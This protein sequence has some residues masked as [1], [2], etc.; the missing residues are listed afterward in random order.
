MKKQPPQHSLPTKLHGSQRLNKLLAA[1]GLGSR[2]QV[3]ELIEQ[4]RV[5]VDGVIAD[6]LGF[7][8]DADNAKILVDGELLRQFRPTYFALNKPAGVLCTNRDP[9]GRPRAIDYLP[10]H[11]RLFPV[12]RLDASSV[13]LLLMTN[14]G[15]L[16]QRL[17]HPKHGVPKTYFVVVAGHIDAQQLKR[18]QRGIYLAEGLAK[19]EGARIKRERKG[20]TELEITLCEGKNREIRRVL[21]KLGNKVVLLRRVS[22]GPL[23]LADLPEGAYRPLAPKEVSAL[24]EAAEES[25]KLRKEARKAGRTRSKNEA[26][27]SESSD[28]AP[29]KKRVSEKSV[30]ARVKKSVL[31]SKRPSRKD[32]TTTD[33]PVASS[34]R[35]PFAWDDDDELLAASPFADDFVQTNSKF[36]DDDEDFDG[37]SSISEDGNMILLRDDGSSSKRQRRVVGF[38]DSDSKPVDRSPRQKGA[39]RRTSPKTEGGTGRVDRRAGAPRKKGMRSSTRQRSRS[40]S[41]SSATSRSGDTVR[42]SRAPSSSSASRPI[43]GRKASTKNLSSKSG[44]PRGKGRGIKKSSRG[45]QSNRNP[46]RR[47]SR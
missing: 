40:G 7:K 44:A 18:L 41:P 31:E 8:V 11:H 17:T 15:E 28:A 25:A 4:G 12:G 22:I 27:A 29:A 26:T 2:R 5:E 34:T 32:S 47:G 6:Q 45:P 10:G 33:E 39:S 36:S 16:T 43:R 13:G 14:D 24:Y 30:Q 42:K 9:E 21:A 20:A 38:E 23:K 3:D 1:A 37:E 19:V 35:D 46:R